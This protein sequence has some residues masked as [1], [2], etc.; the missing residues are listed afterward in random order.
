MNY[1]LRNILLTGLL[2]FCSYL[3]SAIA[4]LPVTTDS[5]IKT[6]VYTPQE[7]YQLKFHFN[8]QSYIEFP[9]VEKIELVAVGD[10]YSWDIKKVDNRL[11]IKPQLA[12]VKTNMTIM[13]D[14]HIYHF[15]I[16]S[17]KKSYHEVDDDLVFVAKFYYPEAAYDYME[18]IRVRKPLEEILAEEPVGQK[19]NN[20]TK[21]NQIASE[22]KSELEQVQNPVVPLQNTPAQTV[23]NPAEK[24]INFNY[25]MVGDEGEVSPVQIFDDGE[26]T[27]LEFASNNLPDIYSVD[28]T[29]MEVVIDYTIE[30][31]LI[32]V[33]GIRRQFTIRN[34]TEL[35]CIFNENIKQ[36]W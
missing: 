6:L 35:L 11:F 34:N 32:K 9:E 29:G 26:N 12:G 23:N 4:V 10:R 13:T 18:S 36:A 22:I 17:S 24:Q 14:K 1:S 20:P 16:V 28:P 5:R 21:T 33:E 8:Y 27:F 15:E 3:N 31:N 30:G 7:I 25:T 19:I 2:F